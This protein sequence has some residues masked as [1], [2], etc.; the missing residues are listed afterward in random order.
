MKLIKSQTHELVRSVTG[1]ELFTADFRYKVEKAEG[2]LKYKGPKIPKQM[3]QEIL[4]FFKWTY[5]TTKSESQVR[6]FVS[7]KH[8]TWRAWAFPQQAE[9]GLSTKELETEEA[10]QQRASLFEKDS[11][12]DAWG[13]VHHHCGISAFQSGTDEHDEQ[14]QGGLHITVGDMDKGEHSI[15]CRLYHQSDRFEP[16]M[17]QF[18]DIGDELA[19]TPVAIL[20]MLPA[21]C[22]DSLARMQMCQPSNVE[23]PNQWKLNYIKREPVEAMETYYGKEY[24]GWAGYDS[25]TNMFDKDGEE[26]TFGGVDYIRVNGHWKR[27]DSLDMPPTTTIKT[28]DERAQ[29]ALSDLLETFNL[30]QMGAMELKSMLEEMSEPEVSEV[31]KGCISNDVDPENILE[32]LE[33]RLMAIS[34]KEIDTN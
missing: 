2:D 31:I 19:F 33:D 23:F 32:A 9:M 18:W 28:V 8:N 21:N 12:W 15:H 30:Y 25:D 24:H 7:S 17:S 5:D 13:T 26:K 16:D 29:E 27:K 6:L 34:G 20:R 22:E 1:G 14:R 11:E 4:S 10:K 3:W